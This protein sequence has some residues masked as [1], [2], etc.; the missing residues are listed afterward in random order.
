[1]FWESFLFR[2]GDNSGTTEKASVKL[3]IVGIAESAVTEG[4]DLRIVHGHS[5]LPK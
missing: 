2:N 4:G 5:S 1:M 3:E